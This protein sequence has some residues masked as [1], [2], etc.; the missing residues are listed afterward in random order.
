MIVI[1]MYNTSIVIL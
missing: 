1:H